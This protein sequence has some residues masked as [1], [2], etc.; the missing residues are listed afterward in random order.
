M[1]FVF[2]PNPNWLLRKMTTYYLLSQPALTPNLVMQRKPTVCPAVFQQ[3]GRVAHVITK[4]KPIVWHHAVW[5]TLF[6]LVWSA[7]THA[8][9]AAAHRFNQKVELVLTSAA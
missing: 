3:C 2:Y 7:E 6:M 4:M 9:A 5:F 8:S 1:Y